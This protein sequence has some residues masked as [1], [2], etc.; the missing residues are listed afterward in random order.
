MKWTHEKDDALR[1]AWGKEKPANIGKR[2]GTTE[3]GAR[4][5]AAVLGLKMPGGSTKATKRKAEIRIKRKWTHEENKILIAAWGE[6]S[7]KAIMRRLGRTQGGI[8][9]QA[10]R[11]KLPP[12]SQGMVS[13]RQLRTMGYDRG[14]VVSVMRSL[15]IEP[16][17]KPSATKRKPNTRPQLWLTDEQANA[18]LER[19]RELP[20]GMRIGRDGALIHPKGTWGVNGKPPACLVHGGSDIE[21]EAGGVCSRCYQARWQREVGH[22]RRKARAA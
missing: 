1:A 17:P 3:K 8:R 20:D 15:G 13:I 2:L 21:H 6:L 5:R 16:N 14:R 4:G 11:L 7:M 12:V 18:V 10:T 9:S 19:L 22:P